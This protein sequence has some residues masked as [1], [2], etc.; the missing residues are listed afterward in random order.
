MPVCFEKPGFRTETAML[1][2]SRSQSAFGSFP[3]AKPTCGWKCDDV[4]P[5]E[6]LPAEGA[7]EKRITW[8]PLFRDWKIPTQEAP[9]NF[10]YCN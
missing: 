9:L 5:S 1:P 10:N 6:N 4:V 8:K 3:A 7:L 2:I